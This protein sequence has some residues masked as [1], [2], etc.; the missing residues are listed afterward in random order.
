MPR[1]PARELGPAPP[2]PAGDMDVS[3]LF[4]EDPS[5]PVVQVDLQPGPAP[6]GPAE[7]PRCTPPS[8]ASPAPDLQLSAPACELRAASCEPC[9]RRRRSCL[10]LASACLCRPQV[11]EDDDQY[12]WDSGAAGAADE[13][14][15]GWRRRR[16]PVPCRIVRRLLHGGVGCVGGDA[17]S[18][19]GRVQPRHALRLRLQRS[20]PPLIPAPAAARRRGLQCRVVLR[21]QLPR[22]AAGQPG[23]RRAR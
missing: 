3:G 11:S 23:Q 22:R 6:P 14:D 21:Q 10:T 16:F 19:A 17:A 9:G 5:C 18:S 15:S 2:H 20:K 13:H 8:P 4:D 7:V 1:V 12:W